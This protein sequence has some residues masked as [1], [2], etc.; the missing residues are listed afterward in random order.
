MLEHVEKLPS[1]L[2]KPRTWRTR[3]DPFSWAEIEPLIERDIGLRAKKVLEDC[4]DG[5][6][7]SSMKVS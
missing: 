1:E 5:I 4:S 6:P 7:N 2:K 3:C